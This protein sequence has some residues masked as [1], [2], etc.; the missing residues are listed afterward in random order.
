MMRKSI[1]VESARWAGLLI[2]LNQKYRAGHVTA[3]HLDWF[4]G[5]SGETRDSLV[6]GNIPM[7]LD[8]HQPVTS[9]VLEHHDPDVFYRTRTG[10]WVSDDFR[11]RVVLNAQSTKAGMQYCVQSFDLTKNLTD[12]K[13]EAGLPA[14]HSFSET[15]V[16]GLIASL[17]VQQPNGEKGE[18]L[19]NGFANLFYTPS[20][21][22]FVYWRAGDRE[23]GVG[24]WQCD[25]GGWSAGHRVFS[26][27]TETEKL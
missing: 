9:T 7:A 6:T 21:V 23:W 16:C 18:L 20:C 27:A 26:L 14:E 11:S 3:D 1:G 25:D 19:N 2:D 17:I 8:H 10:L 22:V 13:I 15:E 5:L 4:N 12:E 24:T